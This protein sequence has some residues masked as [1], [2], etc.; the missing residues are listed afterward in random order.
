MNQSNKT[1]VHLTSLAPYIIEVVGLSRRL[2]E[3]TLTDSPIPYMK[4]Y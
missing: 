1:H 4:N 3:R 2:S